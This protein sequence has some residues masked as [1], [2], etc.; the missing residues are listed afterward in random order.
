MAKQDMLV[1]S[2]KDRDRLKVLHEVEEKHITQRQAAG[3]LGISERWVRELLV[4]VRQKGDRGIVHGLRGRLSNRRWTARTQARAV[5]LVRAKYHDFGPTLAAEY[6]AQE[7]GLEVNKET[8]RQWLM[9]AG[10][11]KRKRRRVE[12]VHLWRARR[13]G[14]G[15]LVQ[16]D[17]LGPRLA[18]RAG[19]KLQQP[20]LPPFVSWHGHPQL[21]GGP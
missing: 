7:E 19:A 15:E 10:I 12:E 18:G 11:W 1:L 8:L 17:N 5:K 2:G 16:W 3:R 4:R 9:A 14:W 21:S 13:A 20:S 6:L